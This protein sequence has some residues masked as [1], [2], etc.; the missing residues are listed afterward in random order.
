MM[1]KSLV[2][3]C[4][5][6]SACGGMQGEPVV[7]D[8]ITPLEQACVREPFN[9][10]NWEQLAAALAIAGERERA[11]TM[12]LQAASLRAHDVRQDYLT[13]KQA[14][15]EAISTMPRTQVRRIGPALVEVSRV[16]LTETA[17]DP[18]QA[19]PVVRLEISNGN[20]VTGAAARLAR[21]LEADGVKTVR[22][23]NLRPFV[24][25]ISRIEY[26]RGQQVM[27]QALARRL[28]LPLQQRQGGTAY[29]EMRIVLGH[30]V[31]YLK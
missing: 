12:Y 2:A 24:V 27:A 30:D 25:P 10:K 7:D 22:L 17:S 15:D 14:R 8:R 19:Q 6:L 23:S 29:A 9:P 21:T 1:K 31:R 5:L 18:V 28:G 20:G 11:A 26:P 16:A 13:V 4:A 3:A